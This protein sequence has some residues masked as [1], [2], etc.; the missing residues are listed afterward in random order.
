MELILSKLKG[1]HFYWNSAEK[2][3]YSGV[4]MIV[5]EKPLSVQFGVGNPDFDNE[6][7]LI[8]LEYPNFYLINGYIPNAGR[9]LVRLE[10]KLNYNKELMK[11]LQQLKKEKNIILC[12]DLNVAHKEIDIAR[13]KSNVKSAGFTPE[14]RESFTELLNLGYVDTFREFVKDGGHYTYW[15]YWGNA[16]EHNTGWRLDY[17]VVNQDFVKQVKTSEILADVLGSDHA[18][19]LLTLQEE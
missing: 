10:F 19:V 11:F 15:A 18:P 5:K 17:F 1:Y 12:G 8:T 4:S 9:G 13:P 6:G 14:E 3:G 7:R 16:R 2:K